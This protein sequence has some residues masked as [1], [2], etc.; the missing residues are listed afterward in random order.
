MSSVVDVLSEDHRRCDVEF[1]QA[2]SA[3]GSGDMTRCGELYRGFR[4]S[5]L[6]HFRMEEEVLFPEFEAATGSS[7][8]PTGIMRQEHQMM[9]ELLDT[10]QRCV[11]E[12]SGADFLG[13][14]DTL[15]VLMQQHNMKE[16]G[17]LYPM[18]DQV[19]AEQWDSLRQR[20]L[21]LGAD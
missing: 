9:R 11:A 10:M 18:C 13:A 3:A 16:E 20:M 1:A 4:A 12:R 21:E 14:A 19:L 7:A 17:I 15:M 6:R 5:L 8:G 2:E